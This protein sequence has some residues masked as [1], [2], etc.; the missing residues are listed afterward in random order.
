M[1]RAQVCKSHVKMLGLRPEASQRAF[2]AGGLWFTHSLWEQR[3]LETTQRFLP[4]PRAYCS[5][6]SWFEGGRGKFLGF[7]GAGE[8]PAVAAVG[9]CRVGLCLRE[10]CAVRSAGLSLLST[11]PSKVWYGV[12]LGP[13]VDQTSPIKHFWL[14]GSGADILT[15]RILADFRLELDRFTHSILATDS[16]EVKPIMTRKLRRRPNDPVPIPDKRR[17]P[18]PDIRCIKP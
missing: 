14:G 1:K 17:K 9:G 10:G 8:M 13:C 7:Q 15:L 16:M 12:W 5:V 4:I 3:E 11:D 18:A 2:H 6:A